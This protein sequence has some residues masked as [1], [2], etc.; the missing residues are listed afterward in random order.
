MKR[1]LVGL[2]VAATL[3]L[4][5]ALA[6]DRVR[7]VETQALIFDAFAIHQAQAEGYFDAENVEV[8]VILGRGGSDSLQAVLTG[9]QDIVYGCGTLS[10]IAAYAKGAP[11]TIIGNSKRGAS[12]IYWFVPRDSRIRSFKDLDGGELAYSSPGSTTHM[13]VQTVA[14]ELG[15]KPRFVAVG[16]MSASRT[17][18]MSGQVQTGY[19]VFPINLDILRKGDIRRIGSGD[20]AAALRDVPARVIAANTNWLAKNRD[21]AARTLRALWKGQEYNFSAGEKAVA[22]FAEHWKIDL[23]GARQV[24]EYFKLEDVSFTPVGDLDALVRM[25]LEYGFIKEP[26]TEAQKQGL[27]SVVYAPGRS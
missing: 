21:V 27:V 11:V 6:K 8:S 4:G 16:N 19:A 9:S 17:Q 20:D 3:S 10:V 12:E 26:L 5:P 2:A 7:L 25:A 1:A 23:D 24:G 14:R 22:R 18:V 13:I 15:I